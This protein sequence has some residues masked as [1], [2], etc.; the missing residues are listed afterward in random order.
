MPLYIGDYQADTQ[1]LNTYQHGAYLLLLMHHWQHGKLPGDDAQLARIAKVHPPHWPRLKRVLM[2]F[3]SIQEDGSY[4]Q[5]R[6]VKELSKAAEISNKRKAAAEQMHQRRHAN[7]EQMHTQSQSQSQLYKNKKERESAAPNG[8]APHTKGSDN[9]AERGGREE[10]G[11]PTSSDN[12]SLPKSRNLRGSRLSENWRLSP[13]D[14]AFARDGLTAEVVG[15]EAEKFRNH[16]ISAPGQKGVKRDWSATW[17]NWCLN[18]GN[19]IPA[20]PSLRKRSRDLPKTK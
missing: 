17:R 15:I 1:H 7:A 18:H 12:P 16:W 5:K 19:G 13:E 4:I 9:S 20:K 3:F 11:S 6:M 14:E 10:G 8:A 2:P